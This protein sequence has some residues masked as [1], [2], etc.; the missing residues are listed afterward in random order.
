MPYLLTMLVG[1]CNKRDAKA[2]VWDY[3]GAYYV[4]MQSPRPPDKPPSGAPGV[5]L[6][7]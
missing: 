1:E 3:C 4:D 6:V 7:A 5:R 2:R